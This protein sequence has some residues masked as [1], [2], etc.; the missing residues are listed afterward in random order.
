MNGLCRK[1]FLVAALLA[2]VVGISGAEKKTAKAVSPPSTIPSLDSSKVHWSVDLDPDDRKSVRVT[3]SLKDYSILY[4]ATEV[5]FTVVF[6]DSAGKVIAEKPFEFLDAVQ[7]FLAGG[8]I[9]ARKFEHGL[10]VRRVASGKVAGRNLICR[11]VSDIQA[12]RP[13][14]YDPTKGKV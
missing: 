4:S 13:T 11:I 9:Y 1:A 3:I 2:S 8:G 6:Y 12:N 10:D 5:S 14:P 7:P